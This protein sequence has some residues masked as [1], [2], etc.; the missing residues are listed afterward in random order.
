MEKA[1]R[2]S[3]KE[4]ENDHTGYN[5]NDS[6]LKDTRSANKGIE[7]ASIAI[8]Q[9]LIRNEGKGSTIVINNPNVEDEELADI[10]IGI[11]VQLD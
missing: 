11:K 6:E 10:S 1:R 7:K 4:K 9:D 8:S 3:T 2:A 5:Q